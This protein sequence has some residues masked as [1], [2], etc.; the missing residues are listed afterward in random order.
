MK[1]LL[2]VLIGLSS[3]I[4]LSATLDKNFIVNP[5]CGNRLCEEPRIGLEFDRQGAL[6]DAESLQWQ[7]SQFQSLVVDPW[8]IQ[9]AD[10][11]ARD[12]A[13]LSEYLRNGNS[14]ENALHI[15]QVYQSDF[16]D[17]R[18]VFWQGPNQADATAAQAMRSMEDTS[19]RLA[20]KFEYRQDWICSALDKQAPEQHWTYLFGR[21]TT[22]HLGEGVSQDWAARY[23]MDGCRRYHPYCFVK[24]CQRVAR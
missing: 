10:L 21:P 15:E 8:V 19:M 5:W 12:I 18:R 11:A 1:L 17:L 6:S 9:A 23:A 20:Q 3:T 7:F 2:A 14:F 4:A 16:A 24:W 13:N 22:G